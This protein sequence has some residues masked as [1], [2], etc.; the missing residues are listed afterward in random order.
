VGILSSNDTSFLQS[1]LVLF[2]WVVIFRSRCQ[3]CA[4]LHMKIGRGA[5]HIM[6]IRIRLPYIKKICVDFEYVDNSCY[7]IISGVLFEI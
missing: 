2:K 7:Q 6:S 1:F 3:L 5:G 4:D